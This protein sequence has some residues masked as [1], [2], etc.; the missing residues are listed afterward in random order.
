MAKRKVLWLLLPTASLS[1]ILLVVILEGY[2]SIA[3]SVWVPY[4]VPVELSVYLPASNLVVP[5]LVAA[6]GIHHG[7][8]IVSHVVGHNAPWLLQANGILPPPEGPFLH[9]KHLE[10]IVLDF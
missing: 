6:Q 2:C 9:T 7:T 8:Y 4:P 3:L 1:T 10:E 5:I